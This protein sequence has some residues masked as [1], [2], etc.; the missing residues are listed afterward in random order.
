MSSTQVLDKM[1]T[2][3]ETEIVGKQ[4]EKK[5]TY[6]HSSIGQYIH[7]ITRVKHFKIRQSCVIEISGIV[8]NHLQDFHFTLTRVGQ[9]DG[10][11]QLVQPSDY[12]ASFQYYKY[13]SG[14]PSC[15]LTSYYKN[16]PP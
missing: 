9:A 12:Q 5:L 4:R 14:Q 16:T 6:T 15:L 10:I 8:T 2:G 1:P 13:L 11:N 7:Q 3:K